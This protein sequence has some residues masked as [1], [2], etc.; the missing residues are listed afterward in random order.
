MKSIQYPASLAPGIGRTDKRQKLWA[1]QRRERGFD[2][3]EIWNVDATFARLMLP[4]VK[5]YITVSEREFIVSAKRKR[6]MAAIVTALELM[7]DC[8]TW[9]ESEAEKQIAIGMKVFARR[10]RGMW[11]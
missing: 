6:D 3:T 8:A 9:H 4:R 2:D 10:I 7:C 1:K 5:E 11:T